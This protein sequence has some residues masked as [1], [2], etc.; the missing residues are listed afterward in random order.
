G[1]LYRKTLSAAEPLVTS[2]QGE[3]FEVPEVLKLRL[4]TEAALHASKQKLGAVSDIQFSRPEVYTGDL[5][6]Y[7]RV[8]RVTSGRDSSEILVQ[9]SKEPAGAGDLLAQAR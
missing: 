8:L 7:L 5:D 2:S 1:V 6:L 3:R 9:L 4:L